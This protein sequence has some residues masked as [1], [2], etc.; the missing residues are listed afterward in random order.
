MRLLCTVVLI[1]FV[2]QTSAHAED[3]QGWSFSGRLSGSANS[4]NAVLKA[5]PTLG[6]TFNR[7]F[8]AYTGLPVYFV[9]DPTRSM[10]GIGNA[11]AGLRFGVGDDAVNYTSNLELTAPTGDRSRGFSTGRVTADWTNHFSRTFSAVTPFGSIGI[12]NT[13][14]DTSF[15]IRPFTSLGLV[16]N[17]DGGATADLSDA[18]RVG[19]SA[20]GVRASGE[21]RII[22][23]V[24]ERPAAGS[25]SPNGRG[26]GSRRNRVFETAAET[27]ATADVANDHGFSTWFGVSPQPQWDFYAGYNRSVNYD[28]NSVFFGVG[29]RVGK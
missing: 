9:N 26:Q 25:G 5:D 2:L 7:Y 14:S 8:H 4:S 11:Y 21:Q 18:F 1:G 19:A 17:F 24:V 28:F 3:G 6:Y 10:S 15:F 13:I 22:S 23:K 29:F 16:S 12:A 20:Y 27:V